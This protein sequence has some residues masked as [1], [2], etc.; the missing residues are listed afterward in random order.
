MIA[1]NERNNSVESITFQIGPSRWVTCLKSQEAAIL[2]SLN[3]AG[4]TIRNCVRPV[5]S[6]IDWRD[7]FKRY[8]ELVG[9]YE[10]VDFLYD[11]NWTPEEW[12]AIMELWDE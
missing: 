9:N 6:N 11:Y 2:E 12:E 5:M 7:A 8:A 3:K 1:M 10:G 4:I